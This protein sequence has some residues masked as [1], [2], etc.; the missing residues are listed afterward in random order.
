[1]PSA[2]SRTTATLALASSTFCGLHSVQAQAADD[3]LPEVVVTAQK[4]AQNLQD[5]GTSITAFEGKDL[6]ALAISN[7]TD[8]AEQTPGLQ[9]NQYGATITVY[10][11]RGVS[12][13]D[14]TD[15]QEAP[16]AVYVDDAYVASLGALSGS[17]FDVARV[18]VL[19]G[20]QGTLFG[21]NAT[22]GLIQYISEA[23][24]FEDSAYFKLGG[25]NFGAVDSEGAVNVPLSSTLAMRFSFATDEHDG[26]I[27]NLI[28][29]DV[30]DQNQYAGRLQLLFR[31]GDQ[32]EI[33][34]KL[35]GLINSNEREGDY[36]WDASRPNALGLGVFTPGSTDFFGYSGPGTPNPFVQELDQ[37]GHFSRT[38][39]G[40]TTHVTWNFDG[41]TLSAVTDYLHLRKHYA[42]DSDMSPNPVFY[43]DVWQG[44]HQFSQELRLNGEVGRLK[45]IG[46]LY[47]LDYHTDDENVILTDP[48]GAGLPLYSGSSPFYS[49]TGLSSGALYSLGTRSGAAFGQ[50]EWALSDRWTG[51]LGVRYSQDWKNY[52]YTYQSGPA[53]YPE[54]FLFTDS[55]T[56]DNVTWKAEL[57]YKPVAS[58]M[59]YVSANRG[60]KSGGWTA[61]TGG[62]VVSTP[63]LSPDPSA[64]AAQL[65][66]GQEILTSYELGSKSTFWDGAARLNASVF[67]YDYQNYQG[68]FVEGLAQA[69][70]NIN[71]TDKGGEVEFS[72][73]PLHG[74]TTE[75][76]L[77]ALDTR[78]KNVPMPCGCAYLD[79]QLPQAPKWSLNASVRY[80]YPT[81]IG[82]FAAEADGKWNTG[83]YFEL[84][85]APVDYQPA[86]L[87][88]NAQLT[89]TS[90][91]GA[92]ELAAGVRNLADKWYR[93]YNLDLSATLGSDQSVYAPPRLWSASVT[94]HWDH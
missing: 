83:Q 71:A 21:R 36:S 82:T 48:S 41:F 6:Q 68:F 60:A 86:Y 38:V 29:S 30:N 78:A 16:V 62:D 80:A 35:H 51:I 43:Y 73:I 13:N 69:V 34:L 18:E 57:D 31:P 27:H 88:A 94:Y 52:S 42:E 47:Y 39:L 26:Y 56:F 93:V 17:M 9:F 67:Y 20:P 72:W 59:L 54:D 76:G 22:G 32:G 28:G 87:V 75:L 90:P 33:T 4:R 3:A 10:N 50:T 45:W 91:S 70:R 12:Q 19:R 23:P 53:P 14:F 8:I 84:I 85:N 61:V 92:W 81:S 24:T 5:V 58:E 37:P 64:I 77:S 74:L 65:R 49:G 79:R 46:G 2:L 1:M 89:Y 15:H 40:A 63:A 66:F 55:R 7:V 11:L 25:G 44:Y